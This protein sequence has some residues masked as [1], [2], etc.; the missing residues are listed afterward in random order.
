MASDRRYTALP[1]QLYTVH[2][3]AAAADGSSE[4]TISFTYR[5]LIQQHGH[6][7]HLD[8]IKPAKGLTVN[9]AYGDTGIRYV[10]I[11]DYIVAARQP[12]VSRLSAMDPSPSVSL[13]FDGC[14]V[15]KGG[16]A[17]VWVLAVDGWP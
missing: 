17:F 8:L 1:R 4:R 15:P 3:G 5:G 11:A 7:L 2:L 14:V 13:T 9:L 16:V 6:L 10:N 12:V